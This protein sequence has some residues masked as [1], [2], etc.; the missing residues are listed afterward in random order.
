MH[1]NNDYNGNNIFDIRSLLSKVC[2]DWL[3]NTEHEEGISIKHARNSGE[4]R[5]GPKQ[6]YVD[7]YC[8]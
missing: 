8:M 6:I 7:G 3:S 5:V 1:I 4:F 2:S